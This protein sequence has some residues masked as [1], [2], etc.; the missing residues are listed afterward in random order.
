VPIKLQTMLEKKLLINNFDECVAT[1]N[2]CMTDKHRLI[3]GMGDPYDQDDINQ[4]AY[5]EIQRWHITPKLT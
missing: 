4:L 1:Y 2:F 3:K 5:D